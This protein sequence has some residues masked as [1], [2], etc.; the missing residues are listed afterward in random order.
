M[1]KIPLTDRVEEILSLCRGKKVLHLG[2]TN[3]PYTAATIADGSLL[4]FRLK[5]V[6]QTVTGFDADNE[7]LEVLR[8]F[9]ET[10][11]HYANLEKLEETDFHEKFEVIVAGEMIEHLNNPGLFLEGI[12]RFLAPDG[13]LMITTINAYCGMRFIV[14]GLRGRGGVM[15]PVHP[16]HV[17]YYSYS[18]L[19]LLLERHGYSV[20]NFVFYDISADD[21]RHNAWHYNLANDISVFFSKQL[22]NGIIATC[23]LK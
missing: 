21:R 22:S 16:D 11:L 9:G 15:E 6:A 7:G 17:A 12:K 18:T 1:G 23:V 13:R 4:H 19:R 5:S 2:C 20:D 8:S 10:D 14:Y 3:Y